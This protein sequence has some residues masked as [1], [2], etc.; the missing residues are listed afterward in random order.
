[1]LQVKIQ[2]NEGNERLFY[3]NDIL[4]VKRVMD[5]ILEDFQ[6]VLAQDASDNRVDLERMLEASPFDNP[7]NLID[8]LN[9]IAEL[10]MG[11][12]TAIRDWAEISDQLDR[13]GY[14]NVEEMADRIDRLQSSINDIFYTAK[15]MAD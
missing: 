4:D 11:D 6:R 15:E 8:W 7:D 13:M 14:D 2:Y 10:T 1:M 5:N 12:H 3:I 9:E